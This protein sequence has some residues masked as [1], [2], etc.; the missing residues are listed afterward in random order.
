MSRCW[1]TL[2]R[3]F[4]CNHP[5]QRHEQV[6]QQLQLRQSTSTFHDAEYKLQADQVASLNVL[7]S[8]CTDDGRSCGGQK[9]HSKVEVK[10]TPRTDQATRLRPNIGDTGSNLVDHQPLHEAAT[11][12]CQHR[13]TKCKI[14]EVAVP[15]LFHYPAF[16]F[17]HLSYTNSRYGL[18]LQ[19]KDQSTHHYSWRRREHH[20]QEY[21]EEIV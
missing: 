6:E 16:T 18:L 4:E 21:A 1:A 10:L 14:G 11:T 5:A 3:L 7:A 20:T 8:S 12:S 13:Y 2:P 17:V 9:D 19:T 15:L